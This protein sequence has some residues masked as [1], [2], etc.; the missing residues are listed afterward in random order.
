LKE[1]LLKFK[2]HGAIELGRRLAQMA[3]DALQERITSNSY[4]IIIPVPLYK[5][6]EKERLFNQS[7]IIA[8]ELS[9]LLKVE[10]RTDLLVRIKPTRQQAKL[11]EGQRWNNVRDAFVV[12]KRAGNQINGK[13][14]LLVDDIVT[15]GAT[16]HE[17]SRPLIEAGVRRLDIFSVA[18][19]R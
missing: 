19:A 5:A 14:V 12:S 3:V 6:R 10:T 15:T 13:R 4:D 8:T 9:R 7:D 2:F 17:A 16:I 18:Y 11:D 1:C